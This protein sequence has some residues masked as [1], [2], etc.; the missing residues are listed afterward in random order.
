MYSGKIAVPP[1]AGS[2]LCEAG[3]D[4][5]SSDWFQYDVVPP[6]PI[7]DLTALD[8]NVWGHVFTHCGAPLYLYYLFIIYLR[9]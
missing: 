4:N 1:G 5:F 7:P 6:T 8:F 3:S 2:R 9:P